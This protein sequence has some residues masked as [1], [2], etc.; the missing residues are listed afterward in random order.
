M[1]TT[2]PARALGYLDPFAPRCCLASNMVKMRIPI[3]EQL[4]CLVLLASTVGLAVLGVATWV[5]TAA[6]CITVCSCC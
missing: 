4:G 3:R 5:H 6:A 1:Q 2:H